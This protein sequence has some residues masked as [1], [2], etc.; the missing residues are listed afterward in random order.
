MDEVPKRIKDLIAVGDVYITLRSKP[1]EFGG[2][3]FSDAEYYV[4]SV[5][6][7]ILLHAMTGEPLGEIGTFSLYLVDGE[8]L[9]TQGVSIYQAYD[10]C[11]E[12]FDYYQ[13]LVS[14]EYEWEFRPLVLETLNCEGQL[15]ASGMLIISDIDIFPGYR[16]NSYGLIALKC[17]LQRFRAGMGIA[18]MRPFP[19]QHAKGMT[20]VKRLKLGLDAYRG[21]ERACLMKLRAHFGRLGFMLIPGTTVMALDLCSELENEDFEPEEEEEDDSA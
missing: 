8:G 17:I 1:E 7:S 11:Q 5:E 15:M 19:W 10:T 14:P 13:E 12:T 2:D 20:L 3:D 4:H 21:S 16:G 9:A 6:G 18:V